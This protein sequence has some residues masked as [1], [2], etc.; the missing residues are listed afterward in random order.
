MRIDIFVLVAGGGLRS[1]NI[2]CRHYGVA[3]DRRRDIIQAAYDIGKFY[4]PRDLRGVRVKSCEGERS[5]MTATEEEQIAVRTWRRHADDMSDVSPTELVARVRIEL[6]VMV[7]PGNNMNRAIRFRRSGH[8]LPLS[9][10]APE[11]FPGLGVET[12]NSAFSRSPDIAFEKSVPEAHDDDTV[13]IYQLRMYPVGCLIMP[14]LFAALKVVCLEITAIVV[15]DE[16]RSTNDRGRCANFVLRGD[17]TC[18]N[19][20]H[21]RSKN[22][23]IGFIVAILVPL[24]L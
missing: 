6:I 9:F 11:L 23:V 20:I 17:E 24:L 15:D 1:L 12:Q 14:Q 22:R 21:R 4:L 19:L 7:V 8:H 10:E 18:V 13:D 5:R 16:H 2:R 3:A